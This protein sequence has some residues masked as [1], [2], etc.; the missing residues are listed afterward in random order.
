MTS[1]V[2]AADGQPLRV[3]TPERPWLFLP[4]WQWPLVRS[5]LVS[6]GAVP[7]AGQPIG[8][9]RWYLGNQLLATAPALA[10]EY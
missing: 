9:V 8:E 4:V 10:S 2:R 6:G 7:V 1:S 3:T 5:Q